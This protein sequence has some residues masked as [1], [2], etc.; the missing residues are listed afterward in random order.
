MEPTRKMVVLSGG[1]CATIEIGRYGQ[2]RVLVHSRDG[3]RVF[4]GYSEAEALEK[5]RLADFIVMREVSE[6][7]TTEEISQYILALPE[8]LETELFPP[9]NDVD[10]IGVCVPRESCANVSYPPSSEISPS[11]KEPNVH[12]AREYAFANNDFNPDFDPGFMGE[13]C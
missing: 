9:S 6:G 11:D 5:L 1:M 12:A 10:S 7:G 2:A 3:S 13:H 8:P 4:E